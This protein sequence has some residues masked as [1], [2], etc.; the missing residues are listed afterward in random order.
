MRSRP[1]AAAIA[2]AVMV[3]GIVLLGARP[4]SASWT[5]NN[6]H[7]DNFTVNSL[8]R[9]DARAYADVAVHE[10]Y[11]WGGGCWNNND[12]DD[13]PGQ[14][15]SG[16]EG[17]DCSGLVFKA[18]E[19]SWTRG[20]LGFRW[21]NKLENR[22]GPYTTRD[23]YS[24]PNGYPFSRTGKSRSNMMYMDA[25]V[26]LDHMGLLYTENNPS[27]NTDYVLEAYNDANGVRILEEGYR[28]EAAFVGSRRANWSP[29]CAPRCR[30]VTATLVVS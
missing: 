3:V 4:G 11:E 30:G 16:G 12:K 14:P 27:S 28:G 23:F 8:R 2:V 5:G 18:W 25:F 6:C 20:A 21:Y 24:P 1:V 15:D 7:A 26:S 22:H 9:I 29:D 13:T 17:P 10:G 19:L